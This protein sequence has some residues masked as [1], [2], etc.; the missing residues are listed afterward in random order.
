MR[1]IDLGRLLWGPHH[2]NI[3]LDPSKIRLRVTIEVV[4]PCLDT[5][6][7]RALSYFV[8]LTIGCM[9]AAEVHLSPKT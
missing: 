4:K 9:K 6:A 1:L 5:I 7:Q 2:A 8:E 3:D